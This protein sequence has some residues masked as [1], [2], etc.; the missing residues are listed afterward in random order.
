MKTLKINDL[1]YEMLVDISKSARKKPEEYENQPLIVDIIDQIPTTI[2][3][4]FA[5]KKLYTQR[6]YEISYSDVKENFVEKTWEHDYSKEV[7]IVKTKEAFI[8][9]ESEDEKEKDDAFKLLEK[10]QEKKKIIP[11]KETKL[12]KENKPKNT[13]GFIDDD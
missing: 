4:G 1:Y 12:K 3:M 6:N 9:S 13:S 8:D 2:F 7:K 11:K 10:E 5:R